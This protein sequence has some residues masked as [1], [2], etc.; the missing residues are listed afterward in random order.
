VKDTVIM[1]NESV[2]TLKYKMI[3]DKSYLSINFIEQL[4]CEIYEE[5]IYLFHWLIII[6]GFITQVH[7]WRLNIVDFNHLD[8]TEKLNAFENTRSWCETL[9]KSRVGTFMK[10]VK[11]GW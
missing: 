7:H 9:V 4:L 5:R 3:E 6:T 1:T 2:K 8:S 10:F 11:E